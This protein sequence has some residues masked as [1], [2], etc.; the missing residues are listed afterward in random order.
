MLKT[1]SWRIASVALAIMLLA[2][3]ILVRFVQAQASSA[4]PRPVT[5]QPNGRWE[6]NQSHATAFDE[7][8]LAGH[9]DR[10][11]LEDLHG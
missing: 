5:A 9:A 11:C 8:Y 7:H 3:A 6:A 4:Q 1:N 10:S 2:S